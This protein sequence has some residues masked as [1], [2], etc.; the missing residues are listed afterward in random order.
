MK[1]HVD[2]MVRGAA[3]VL[4]WLPPAG[5]D[6]LCDDSE[7]CVEGR[8][9]AKPKPLGEPMTDVC[10]E[11]CSYLIPEV[12]WTTCA[13]GAGGCPWCDRAHCQGGCTLDCS[14]READHPIGECSGSTGTYELGCYCCVEDGIGQLVCAD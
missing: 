14:Q 10:W 1:V 2:L 3:I 4:L 9:R 8:C 13:T 11:E 6:D 5:C 7:R 12:C